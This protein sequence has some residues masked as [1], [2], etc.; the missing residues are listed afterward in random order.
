MIE[1][2]DRKGFRLHHQ[3]SGFSIVDNNVVKFPPE[4]KKTTVFRS[5]G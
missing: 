2:N 1:N 3:S 4:N 5:M